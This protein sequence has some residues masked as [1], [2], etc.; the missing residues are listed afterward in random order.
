MEVNP[1]LLG[2]FGCKPQIGIS[3]QDRRID[4]CSGVWWDGRV[5]LAYC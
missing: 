4:F 5:R 3:I 2:H 1:V